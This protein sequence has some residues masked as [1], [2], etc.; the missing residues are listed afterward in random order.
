MAITRTS[1][2]GR[3]KGALNKRTRDVI[4]KLAALHCD[5]IEGMARL[6]MDKANPPELRGRMFAELAQYIA[7]KRKAVE[8][9]ADG[10]TLEE[11]LLKLDAEHVDGAAA[12]RGSPGSGQ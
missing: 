9:S 1:G 4:E 2:Q 3:P 5:P 12:L 6:A 10:A 8:H 7:P 11:L